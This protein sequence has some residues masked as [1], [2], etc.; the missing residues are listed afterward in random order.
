MS[1]SSA[2][3]FPKTSVFIPA[4]WTTERSGALTQEQADAL[5]LKFPV[6]QG[7]ESIPN[8]IVSGTS[9]LGITS[10]ST[11]SLTDTTNNALT[12]GS[13]TS[14]TGN[15]NFGAGAIQRLTATAGVNQ[16]L[17]LYC[18]NTTLSNK[19]SFIQLRSGNST[20]GLSSVELDALSNDGYKRSNGLLTENTLNLYS[21]FIDADTTFTGGV[22]TYREGDVPVATIYS[23]LYSAY[24]SPTDNYIGLRARTIQATSVQSLEMFVGSTLDAA[25]NIATFNGSGLLMYKPI[26]FNADSAGII[27]RTT[28]TTLGTT[29][30]FTLASNGLTF[31]SFNVNY[32]G[33]ATSITAYSLSGIPLNCYYQIAIYNGGSGTLIM[34]GVGS[35]ANSVKVGGSGAINSFQIPTGRYAIGELRYVNVNSTNFYFFNFVIVG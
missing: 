10:A 5:Y 27:N 26:T 22:A 16:S 29:S 9:T 33:G 32:S 6:G 18:E 28:T 20:T 13:G 3:I 25:V 2:P 30:T 23:L 35:G 17:Q 1:S 12:I 4:Y 11:L 31:R 19:A 24:T 15:M 34:N 7:T 8:L 14:A 21:N